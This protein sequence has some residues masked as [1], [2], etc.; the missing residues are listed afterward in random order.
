M[1]FY[2]GQQISQSAKFIGL[3]CIAGVLGVDGCS[4]AK[5]SAPEPNASPPPPVTQAD[6]NPAAQP[7]A[8]APG[9]APSTTQPAAPAEADL[10]ALQRA[11]AGWL[12]AHRRVP[13]NFEEFAAT[14]GVTI[15]P[16]P[17]GKKYYLTKRMRIE[18]V[19][20]NSNP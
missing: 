8:Q 16:P 18:L 17:P 12:V 6:T 20:V 2:S 10:P 4:K 9:T 13:A 5:T 3:V 1:K 7:V 15:P 19:D 14:A 11:L